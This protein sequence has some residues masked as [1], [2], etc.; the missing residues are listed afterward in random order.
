[1][2]IKSEGTQLPDGS[3]ARKIHVNLNTV[4]FVSEEDGE[5]YA[6]YVNTPPPYGST[7]AWW[8]KFKITGAPYDRP[9]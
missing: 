9:L 8:L 2:W 7:V 5:F 3:N 4:S 6:W 1:M